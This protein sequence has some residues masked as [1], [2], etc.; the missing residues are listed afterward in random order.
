MKPEAAGISLTLNFIIRYKKKL[1]IMHVGIDHGQVPGPLSGKTLDRH[2]QCATHEYTSQ[3][4]T[5]WRATMVAFD[6]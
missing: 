2:F 3:A 1:M 6:C 4:E 5:G